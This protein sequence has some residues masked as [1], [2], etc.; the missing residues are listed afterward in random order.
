MMCSYKVY[1]YISEILQMA[2]EMQIKPRSE[3][4]QTRQPKCKKNIELNVS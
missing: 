4:I 2:K 3:I 1:N